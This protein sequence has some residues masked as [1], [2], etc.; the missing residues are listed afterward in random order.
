MRM[1]NGSKHDFKLF[2]ETYNSLGISK[3]IVIIGDSGYQGI[4]RIHS[5][6]LIPCKRPCKCSDYNKSI[7]KLR[8]SVE[9]VIRELKKFEIIG[10]KN[11]DR[12]KRFELRVRLISGIYNW[13][14]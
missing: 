10:G 1:S 6:S 8:I 4:E 3:D 13:G 2:K 11:R 9:H 12:R 7:A 14:R 5:N